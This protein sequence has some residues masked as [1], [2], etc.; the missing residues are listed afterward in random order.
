MHEYGKLNLAHVNIMIERPYITKIRRD[1]AMTFTNYV[2]NA[3]GLIGLCIGF[4]FISCIEII[5]WLCTCCYEFKSK[6]WS[7]S[8]QDRAKKC[9][10][11]TVTSSTQTSKSFLKFRREES[12][13]N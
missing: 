10:P 5:F 6:V 2:A 12:S 4:S 1:V 11:E 13:F 9:E 8:V 3:G 7:N